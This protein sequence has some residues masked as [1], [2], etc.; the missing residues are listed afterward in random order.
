[1]S[2]AGLFA[3]LLQMR[4]V[5]DFGK[6]I[7]NRRHTRLVANA[8]GFDLVVAACAKGC[9]GKPH[10]A[11]QLFDQAFRFLIEHQ[12]NEMRLATAPFDQINDLLVLQQVIVDI[13]DRLEFRM[14]LLARAEDIGM[15]A[16]IGI[17]IGYVFEILAP[18]IN[19]K[20]VEIGGGNKID[21]VFISMEIAAYF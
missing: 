12:E 7:G 15:T 3:D 17:D 16:V 18:F 4:V 20:Q 19:A 10:L 21:R 1:M 13:L 8:H 11:T 2:D 5:L 6:R 9:L 14:R